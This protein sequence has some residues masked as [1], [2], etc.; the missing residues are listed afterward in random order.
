M[1]HDLMEGTQEA[2]EAVARAAFRHGTTSFLPT[3]LSAPPEVLRKSLDGLRNVVSGWN[4]NRG[5]PMA[6]PLGI[7]L[8]GPFISADCR[9]AHPRADLQ[10]PSIS[11]FQQFLDAAGDSLRI[12]P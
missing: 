5:A 1:A 8:E 12:S 11:L 2:V 9:G 6:F 7:H 10:T 3:T 4:S